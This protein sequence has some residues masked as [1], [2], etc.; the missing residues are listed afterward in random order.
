MRSIQRNVFVAVALVGTLLTTAAGPAFA[1]EVRGINPPPPVI[2]SC[3]GSVRLA[4]GTIFKC[5]G[6]VRPIR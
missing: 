6:S 5:D 2:Y 1:A 3:D 4:P